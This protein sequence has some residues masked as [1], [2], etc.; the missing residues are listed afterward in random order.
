MRGE[1][2]AWSTGRDMRDFLSP[3]WRVK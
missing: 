3:A 2:L 1:A